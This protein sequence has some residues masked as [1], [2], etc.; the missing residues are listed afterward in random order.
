MCN[1]VFNGT[2]RHKV[3]REG[4]EYVNKLAHK[5]GAV[6]NGILYKIEPHV[7]DQLI[8]RSFPANVFEIIIGRFIKHHQDEVTMLADLPEHDRPKRINVYGNKVSSP[9]MLGVSVNRA[10][11]GKIYVN[12]RTCYKERNS[13][14]RQRVL[15]TYK[16]RVKTSEDV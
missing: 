1:S 15:D 14:N 4:R 13:E 12:I 2:N 7:I 9:Y 6:E 8:S 3:I 16:I 11:T 10:K 5:F